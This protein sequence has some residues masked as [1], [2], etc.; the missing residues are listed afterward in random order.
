MPIQHSVITITKVKKPREPHPYIKKL[1]IEPKIA[2]KITRINP[3]AT[4][5]NN[6]R[7]K[8]HL[9]LLKNLR[10]DRVRD[11]PQEV[12]PLQTN[13]ISKFLNESTPNNKLYK[14]RNLFDVE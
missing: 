11:L 8:Q 12:T 9:D 5:N 6:K 2:P 4:P 13:L 14:F 1:F 7:I 3:P 10:V